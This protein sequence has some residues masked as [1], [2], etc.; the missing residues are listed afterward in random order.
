LAAGLCACLAVM[1][2]ATLV[3]PYGLA[4]H[5]QVVENLHA[6][7]TERFQDFRP[8]DFRHGGASVGCFELLIMAVIVVTR[9]GCARVPWGP[10]V[11]LVGT[12]Q[13]ALPAA[14]NM[15]FFAIVATPVVALGL[16]G[17][18]ADRWPGLHARWEAI[19]LAQEAGAAWR[20][21]ALAIAVLCC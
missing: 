1:A 9:G 5:R 3:N 14:R 11:L 13:L 2:L 17:V 16:T 4:L 12:L 19:G 20:V 7:S 15:N 21:P 8:P 10:L 6:P 18:I